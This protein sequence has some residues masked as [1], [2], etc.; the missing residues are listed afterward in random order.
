VNR[1]RRPVTLNG[2]AFE[3]SNDK[4]IMFLPFQRWPLPVKLDEGESYVNFVIPRKLQASFQEQPRGTRLTAL[5]FYAADGREFREPVPWRSAWNKGLSGPP[6]PE[7][8][9]VELL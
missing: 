9:N 8:E 3:L 4:R 6:L 2:F 5:V 1:G 7:A